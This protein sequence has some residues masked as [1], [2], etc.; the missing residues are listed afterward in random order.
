[1]TLMLQQTSDDG[2]ARAKRCAR[3]GVHALVLLGAAS[4]CAPVAST[5]D[6]DSNT[7]STDT[8]NP[9][10]PEQPTQPE[11]DSTAQGSADAVVIENEAAQHVLAR[12]DFPSGQTVRFIEMEPGVVMMLESGHEGD[13]RLL[14]T[15]ATAGLTAIETY[16][17]FAQDAVP[18]ALLDADFRAKE[19]ATRIGKP[20]IVRPVL[21]ETVEENATIRKV[22]LPNTYFESIYCST[23]GPNFKKSYKL[24]QMQDLD[25]QINDVAKEVYS[26]FHVRF[27][28]IVQ[29]TVKATWKSRSGWTW[30]SGTSAVLRGGQYIAAEWPDQ[31]FD[32]DIKAAL[33]PQIPGYTTYDACM[34]GLIRLWGW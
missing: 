15:E 20:A 16:E 34:S 14:G 10:G 33:R 8:A 7:V 28:P 12:I 1:M 27:D 13:P 24:N 18:Q 17:F 5:D 26:A 3:F 22:G 30:S 21:D 32:F 11:S 4:A 31:P 29:S 9:A 23:D 2:A 25:Q 6:G 19:L